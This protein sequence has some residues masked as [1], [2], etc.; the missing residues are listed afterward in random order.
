MVITIYLAVY[1]M[2]YAIQMDRFG[3]RR[4]LV[5]MY[6]E[7]S[8]SLRSI[9][10]FSFKCSSLFLYFLC[11]YHLTSWMFTQ[12]ISHRGK[13]KL[14]R[15]FAFRISLWKCF[16]SWMGWLVCIL[17]QIPSYWQLLWLL[18]QFGQTSNILFCHQNHF[19]VIF[20][21]LPHSRP[22]KFCA[23]KFRVDKIRKQTGPFRFANKY[24]IIHFK[25]YHERSSFRL[26]TMLN[27][28]FYSQSLSYILEYFCLLL[29]KM[30]PFTWFFFQPLLSI[31]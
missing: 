26:I 8:S 9:M 28:I 13:T 3:V 23:F 16:D 1:T 2:L 27:L 20:F 14:K 29:W 19:S 6:N 15:W 17:K 30:F 22:G 4:C 18:F 21:F 31:L 5:S 11:S 24:I 12:Q 7:Y 25:F 10:R